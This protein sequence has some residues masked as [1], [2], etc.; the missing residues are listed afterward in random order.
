MSVA[1]YTEQDFEDH[2]AGHLATSGFTL[3]DGR[4]PAHR[5]KERYDPA[6]CL[7]T[8]EVIAFL[9]DTQPKAYEQLRK[10]YGAQTDA[11]ILNR[12][13]TEIEKW[14]TLH[15]LR[16]G[17]KDRG[18]RLRFVFFE[19]SSGLNP[20][21]AAL[22]RKNRFTVVRQLRFS[23]QTAQSLDLTLFLN[24]IPLFT[25]EVKNSL[26]GQTV[27]HA[28][29]QYRK[30]RF[31]K[32]PLFR[33]RRCLA[34][35]A[36]GNEEV[37]YTTRLQ[38]EKTFFLPFNRGTEEGGKGNPVNPH[39]HKT[40]YLWE[41]VWQPDS[42]LDLLQNYLH[43]QEVSERVFDPAQ[44]KV[45]EKTEERLIFPRFH[46]LDA[47][48]RI[49]RAA[50]AEGVGHNYLIQHSAGSGKSNSIAWLAHQLARLYPDPHATERLF[51]SIIVITDRRVLD[52]QL[53]RT[54]KQ[55]EQVSGVVMPIDA[56]GAQLKQALE[57]G[58][59]IIVT[60]LQKFPVISGAMSGL[61]GRRFAVIIDEAHSSQSGESA[62][63]LKKTLSAGLEE[64]E[65]EDA[66]EE[67]D[68]E[69]KI[70]AEIKTRGRQAH[71]SY[72]AFTATPKPKTLELFGRKDASGNYVAFHTYSMRQAIEERFILDVLENYTTFER[73]FKL[74]KAIEEDKEYERAKAVRALTSWVDLQDHAIETKTRIMLDH[75]LD[76]TANAIRGKGR[77]M[78]VTRSRLHAVRY[79]LKFRKLIEEKGL[80]FKPLVAFSG[81][82]HDP[83]T[84]ADH[85]ENSLNRLPPKVSIP[86]AFKYPEYRILIAANKFQTGFDEPLLHTMYVD[87]KLGG[88]QAVQTL[89]RLNRT[90]WRQGKTET[91]VLDFVNEAPEIQE[92]FQ[93]YYQKTVLEEETDPN[94]LYDL[95]TRMELL[96]VYTEEDINAFAEIFFD[97][98]Q[99]GERLQPILDAVVDRWRQRK[100]DDRETFRSLLQ[101]YI[102][103]YGYVSQLIS[104]QDVDLEKL[105]VFARSLN[106]KLPRREGGGLPL[107]VLDAVDLDSFRI[108]Q[109]YK[110]R[111]I[112]EKRDAAVYGIPTQSGGPV[113]EPEVDFLSHIVE[114]LNETYGLGLTER[115]KVHFKQIIEGVEQDEEALA[116]LRGNNSMSNKRRAVD[117]VVDRHIVEQVNVSVELFKKLMEPSINALVKDRL[118][119]RLLALAREG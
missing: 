114:T 31:P 39:G 110:D 61:S 13:R 87:K 96:E 56:T 18:Q 103:L 89:S 77:A 109:T 20:E 21:H 43:L 93:K 1:P 76:V 111:I 105:Y 85:T 25:A 30:D 70:I 86:D 34:H 73:Y 69:D 40:A 15:V 55:F 97:E 38:G 10:Q 32:E 5:L 66:D 79:Y 11:G 94:K 83:D 35:F 54:I 106:R 37:H 49:L 3:L 72:F 17:F 16:K 67:P 88:V 64:A 12:L 7:L 108:R 53:Q 101:A 26:T 50:K 68:L 36:V 82:V 71:I 81:T 19:P 24:G 117:Q 100:E 44:R 80:P 104:F 99:P 29:K 113:K 9:K 59:D 4:D 60:T 74:V 63:H 116:V 41:D 48:R 27:E 84:G 42:I 22:Y 62:K 33:F 52:A 98:T 92:A 6:R 57:Q 119:K 47:V 2:I 51:D 28:M 90:A 78:L 118:F 14:G 115:D 8:D 23:E 91:V 75:F 107:E 58:K 65:A 95:Q 112:L 45:V 46:Q 102:R